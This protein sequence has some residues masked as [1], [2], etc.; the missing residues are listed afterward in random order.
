MFFLQL[1]TQLTETLSKLETEESERQK[2]AGDLYKVMIFLFVF[3]VEPAV[4]SQ[5]PVG[6]KWSSLILSAGPAVC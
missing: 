2:V 4:V 6:S 5:I 1:K 3:F